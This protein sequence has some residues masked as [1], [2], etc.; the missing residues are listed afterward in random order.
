MVIP[1]HVRFRWQAKIFNCKYWAN[2]FSRE[3]DW[4]DRPGKM[5]GIVSPGLPGIILADN[6]CLGVI[7]R[8]L[9]RSQKY[10]GLDDKAYGHP[11]SNV[12]F[13]NESL[14]FRYSICGRPISE[15]YIR[16]VRNGICS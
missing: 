8:V 15:G 10:A 14:L 11:T 3:L 7:A 2:C 13:S 6:S 5:G 4:V 1:R 9:F 16:N 12:L